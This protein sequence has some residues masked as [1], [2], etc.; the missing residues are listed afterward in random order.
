MKTPPVNP[1]AQQLYEPSLFFILAL[2]SPACPLKTPLELKDRS[3]HLRSQQT[4]RS[5]NNFFSSKCSTEH[6]T[7]TKSLPLQLAM[8]IKPRG[9]PLMVCDPARSRCSHFSPAPR[10]SGKKIA[11]FSI[12][13]IT[14]YSLASISTQGSSD[15]ISVKVVQSRPQKPSGAS[16]CPVIKRTLNSQIQ[17]YP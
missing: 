16:Y 13:V 5:R 9:Y 2:D 11:A 6:T 17:K 7:P 14:P 1:Q 3:M 8:Q 10:P 4:D 15:T 12:L